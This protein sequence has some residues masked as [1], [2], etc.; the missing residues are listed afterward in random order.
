MK[1]ILE[2]YATLWEA[3]KKNDRFIGETFV[4]RVYD[5]V[6]PKLTV[7]D[8]GAFTGEFSFSCLPF[9]KQIYAI[10]PDPVPFEKMKQYTEDFGT[11]EVM[12]IFNFAI[13]DSNGTRK[14]DL[15][16]AGGSRITTTGDTEVETHT[17]KD[18]M[19]TNKIDHINILKVDI[20][21]GEDEIFA[22][23]E[24][25]ELIPKIDVII[26]EHEGF[27]RLEGLGFKLETLPNGVF[28]ATK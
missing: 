1:S 3:V 8:L 13:A 26:G 21:G 11:D 9:A 15:T 2:M 19:E 24:F 16:H 22:S 17:L 28:L 18:F 20:E 10:E 5:A 6:H 27:K 4:D 25:K 12:H 14:M 23:S 7:V